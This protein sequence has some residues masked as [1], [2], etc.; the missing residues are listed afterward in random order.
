MRERIIELSKKATLSPREKS[1]VKKMTAEL[2]I[3]VNY[4]SGCNN[5]Y[6]DALA[7]L[8]NHYA[9]IAEEVNATECSNAEYQYICNAARVEWYHDGVRTYLS[10][11]SDTETIVQFIESNPS[12]TIFKKL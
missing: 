4:K 10:A 7:L 11:T 1:E 8:R 3:E 5:C 2:G 12:Q 6:D 9:I